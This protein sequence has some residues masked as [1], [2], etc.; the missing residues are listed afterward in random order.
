[1]NL[2]DCYV[3]EVLATKRVTDDI[4]GCEW[5]AE[6]MIAYKVRYISWGAV[7]TTEIWIKESEDEGQIKKGYKFVQ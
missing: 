5:V 6:P 3:E 1:M 7:S 4:P 2:V